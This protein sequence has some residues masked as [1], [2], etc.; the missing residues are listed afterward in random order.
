[1]DGDWLVSRVSGGNYYLGEHVRAS[2]MRSGMSCIKSIVISVRERGVSLEGERAQ[3]CRP[4]LI[5]H[6]PW[7][8]LRDD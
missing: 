1:M 8:N 5:A 7:N 4:S 6:H 2:L 3:Y